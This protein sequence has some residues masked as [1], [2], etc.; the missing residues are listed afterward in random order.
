VLQYECSYIQHG[1]VA[2]GNKFPSFQCKL[3]ISCGNDDEQT[4]LKWDR[5]SYPVTAPCCISDTLSLKYQ[6]LTDINTHNVTDT[7]LTQF[8]TV[9]LSLIPRTENTQSAEDKKKY[10]LLP[11]W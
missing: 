4:A 7:A 10:I 6:I 8:N 11:I 2:H 9:Y 3:L 5:S 1:L